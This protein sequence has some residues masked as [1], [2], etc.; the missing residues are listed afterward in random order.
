MKKEIRLFPGYDK[1]NPSPFKNYGISG[2]NMCFYL[3]GDKGT[4]QFVIHLDWY[5]EHIQRERF[6]DPICDKFFDIKPMAADLGYYSPSP[7]YEGQPERECDFLPSGKCFYDGSVLNA[8]RIR[9]IM[10][11][12]GDTGVWRELESYYKT[13]FEGA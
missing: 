13:I 12:E 4:V 5:P 10:L 3:H 2:G 7:R 1:R 9:D 6:N 8:E 11:L